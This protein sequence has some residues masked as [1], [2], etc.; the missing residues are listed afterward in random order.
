VL[1]LVKALPKAP[2][3]GLNC[4]GGQSSSQL[5]KFLGNS[6]TLVTYGGMSKQPVTVSTS[7]LIFKNTN[8]KG[9]WISKWTKENPPEARRE[10]LREIA[11]MYKKKILKFDYT[12]WDYKNFKDAISASLQ[13]NKLKKNILTF[14]KASNKCL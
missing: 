9:F 10:M 4:V 14:K 8:I 6:G 12:F 7:S 1:G 11:E 2:L 3:L 13:G 5:V